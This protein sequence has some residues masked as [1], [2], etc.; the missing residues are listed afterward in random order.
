MSEVERD[1]RVLLLVG[2][3]GFVPKLQQM[4][5]QLSRCQKS[6]N[7]FLEE[8]RSVFPRFYFIGDDDLLEILGQATEP[9]IIQ[10]HLKKLFAGIH[11]VGFSDDKKTVID[12]RSQSGEVVP[13]LSPVKITINVEDWL[14]HLAEAMRQALGQSLLDCVA[15]ADADRDPNQFPSQILCLAEQVGDSFLFFLILL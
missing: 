11:T 15:C 10:T 12:M 8:K 2:R 7:E 13:L 4:L 14:G 5:D 1:P 3:A 6:L 9:T